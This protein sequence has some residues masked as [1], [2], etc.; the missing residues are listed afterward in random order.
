MPGAFLLDAKTDQAETATPRDRARDLITNTLG[1]KRCAG[2]CNVSTNT[3][4]Q[5]LT[6][7]TD[8]RPIPIDQAFAIAQGA[9]AEGRD[10][11]LKVLAPLMPDKPA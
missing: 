2:W 4:Y 3:V 6:R 1:A 5:W 7:G 8:E 10:C 11:D 9:W